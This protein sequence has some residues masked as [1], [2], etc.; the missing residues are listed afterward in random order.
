MSLAILSGGLYFIFDI[1]L[2]L[3]SLKTELLY[4]VPTNA[5]YFHDEELFGPSGVLN[6]FTEP[7]NLKE[8][9][10]TFEPSK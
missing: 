1:F 7:I 2:S 6:S 9:L 4:F 5:T 3:T 8:I 10:Y